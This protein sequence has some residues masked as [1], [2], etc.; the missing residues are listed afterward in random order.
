MVENLG[1]KGK[2]WWRR[3]NCLVKMRWLPVPDCPSEAPERP[4]K[5]T[6][7]SCSMRLKVFG[8]WELTNST[9][10]VGW[11]GEFLGDWEMKFLRAWVDITPKDQRGKLSGMAHHC[12]SFWQLKYLGSVVTALHGLVGKPSSGKFMTSSSREVNR[13]G[14]FPTCK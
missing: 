6:S 3:G 8:A 10:A 13:W 2:A 4:A 12:I 9:V 7:A 1:R 14:E 5:P 11:A